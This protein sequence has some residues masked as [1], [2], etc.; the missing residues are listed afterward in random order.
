M[1]HNKKSTVEKHVEKKLD[2]EKIQRDL[3][4]KIEKEIAKRAI[5][6]IKKKTEGKVEKAVAKKHLK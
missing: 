1:E 6:S 2:L 3:S 5:T 4:P